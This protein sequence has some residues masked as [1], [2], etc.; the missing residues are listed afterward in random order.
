MRKIWGAGHSLISLWF[1]TLQWDLQG[2]SIWCRLRWLSYSSCLSCRAGL[3]VSSLRWPWPTRPVLGKCWTGLL[4]FTRWM[5]LLFGW[6]SGLRRISSALWTAE[7]PSSSSLPLRRSR[8]PTDTSLDRP[9]DRL[10]GGL[11]SRICCF[12][13]IRSISWSGR[14]T[15][16]PSVSRNTFQRC[17]NLDFAEPTAPRTSCHSMALPGTPVCRPSDIPFSRCTSAESKI[18]THP[19][20]K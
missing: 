19:S 10:L 11:G 18:G 17:R 16:S 13:T 5:C 9:R 6:I 2:S 1:C 20:R 8:L 3:L 12:L 14:W 15:T 4:S 7:W